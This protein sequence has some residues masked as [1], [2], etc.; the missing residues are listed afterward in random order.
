[1]TAPAITLTLVSRIR[2]AA[3]DETYTRPPPD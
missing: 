2:T 1:M 3:D